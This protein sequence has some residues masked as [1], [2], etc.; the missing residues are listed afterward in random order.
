MAGNTWAR[1]VPPAFSVKADAMTKDQV[2]NALAKDSEK[3]CFRQ[4]HRTQ[5]RV[6]AARAPDLIVPFQVNRQL[7]QPVRF[8]DRNNVRVLTQTPSQNACPGPGR[9][10]YKNRFVYSVL[11]SRLDSRDAVGPACPLGRYQ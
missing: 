11:H 3:F 1:S 2:V 7:S 5:E 10:H 8:L 6:I 9:P 4:V